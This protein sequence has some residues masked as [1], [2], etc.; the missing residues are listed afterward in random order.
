MK[1]VC[2]YL[3][4][5]FDTDGNLTSKSKL[6]TQYSFTTFCLYVL[7]WIQYC[8]W[9]H[10]KLIGLLFFKKYYTYNESLACPGDN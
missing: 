5:T 4:I 3:G 1:S 9:L 2:M 7:L 10:M 8:H 6:C